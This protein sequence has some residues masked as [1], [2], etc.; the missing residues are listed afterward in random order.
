MAIVEGAACGLQVVSTAVGGIPEV[1]PMHCFTGVKEKMIRL[2]PNPSITDLMQVLEEAIEEER[3]LRS[4]GL[5][6]ERF[7]HVSN[8][9]K[10]MYSW[11]SVAKRTEA[12]YMRIDMEHC[13]VPL[14][15]RLSRYMTSGYWAGPIWCI[16][17]CWDV[18][19]LYLVDWLQ[20][21]TTKERSQKVKFY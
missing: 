16:M 8:A 11:E 7:Y 19:M 14:A 12:V 17:V 1:L 2:A 6:M 10:Q 3:N 13:I 4:K 9:V 21:T 20:Q 15:E 5:S 18:L